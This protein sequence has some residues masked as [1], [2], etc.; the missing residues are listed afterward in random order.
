MFDVPD[1]SPINP[2]N[3]LPLGER[4]IIVYVNALVDDGESSQVT[5]PL[6]EKSPAPFPVPTVAM[7]LPLPSP[8][9]PL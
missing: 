7:L 6:T 4:F 3:E 5:V 2:T 1:S 9:V 8:L